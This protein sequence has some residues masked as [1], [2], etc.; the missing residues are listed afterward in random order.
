ME[1]TVFMILLL[2][3]TLG[4]LAYALLRAYRADSAL[5]AARLHLALDQIQTEAGRLLI[6][7][8]NQLSATDRACARALSELDHP[9]TA[10]TAR[11]KRAYRASHK[12]YKTVSVT[13]HAIDAVESMLTEVEDPRLHRLIKQ[14]QQILLDGLEAHLPAA[15][16]H[17]VLSPRAR[18]ALLPKATGDRQLQG[19]EQWYAKRAYEL[20]G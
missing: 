8:R 3:G 2:I 20:R 5:S 17:S 7:H 13:R 11:L 6:Y 10:R 12:S 9:A 15:S 16:L 14:Y 19:L 4:I 18:M 1:V